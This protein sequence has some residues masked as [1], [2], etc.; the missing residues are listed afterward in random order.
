MHLSE[1]QV[2]ALLLFGNQ[3][4]LRHLGLSLLVTRLRNFYRASPS[5]ENLLFCTDELNLFLH[6]F[7]I[8]LTFDLA[9]INSLKEI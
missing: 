2:K 3:L 6:K 9:Q 4:Q 7:E 1:T 5:P 8:L